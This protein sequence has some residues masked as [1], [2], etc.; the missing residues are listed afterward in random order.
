[1][2]VGGVYRRIRAFLEEKNIGV[3][4]EYVHEPSYTSEESARLRGERL[5]IGGKA[6]L[7]KAKDDFCLFVF[8][9]ARKADFKAIKKILGVKSLRLATAEELLDLTREADSPDGSG[10]V[11]GSVPPFGM[12]ILPFRLFVDPS[13]KENSQIA[14]NA[15][16]L[17]HS[18]KLSTTDYLGVC[19]AERVFS[20]T[21]AQDTPPQ[22]EGG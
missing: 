22:G 11:P 17:T 7:M 10:C 6:L 19:G 21:A 5:E 16:S 8:S 20:F 3:L 12:P 13:V 15:G 4:A 2:S 9:A 14:F 1:M 18:L